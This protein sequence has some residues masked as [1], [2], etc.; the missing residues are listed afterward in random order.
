MEVL[1][2]DYVIAIT[3]DKKFCAVCL[4]AKDDFDSWILGDAFMRNWYSIHDLDNK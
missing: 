2:E 4:R 3:T 1:P